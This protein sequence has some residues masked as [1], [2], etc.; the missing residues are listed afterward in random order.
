MGFRSFDGGRSMVAGSRTATKAGDV[1]RTAVVWAAGVFSWTLAMLVLAG[2]GGVDDG[3]RDVAVVSGTDPAQRA[4][5]AGGRDPAQRADSAGG[6]DPAQRAD[7][8][9]G[10]DPA[11]R[12]DSAGGR[13][14]AQHADSASPGA[15]SVQGSESGASDG[16]A[17]VGVG[18]APPPAGGAAAPS[19]H[20]RMGE[21][22]SAG[23]RAAVEVPASGPQG[24][25]LGPVTE[26]I[27]I[28]D[29]AE[30]GFGL[31][32]ALQKDVPVEEVERAGP[33]GAAAAG[34]GAGVPPALGRLYIWQ[35]G[36][37]THSAR[38]VLDR[39]VLDDGTV[40]PRDSV[41]DGSG[42]DGAG[43]D[44]AGGARPVFLSESGEQM[45]LPGGVILVLDPEWDADAVAGFLSRNG[46][47]PDRVSEL[48]YLPN[49]FVVATEP[50]FASLDLANALAGQA[51]VEIASPN[52]SREYTAQ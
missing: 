27:E 34:V 13:D 37:R 28:L 52:W 2:C 19:E 23:P 31:A 49:G 5:S 42:A 30:L 22:L 35:D 18:P 41:A 16:L 21:D 47:E 29:P 15:E 38:L 10:R 45:T 50:G 33:D 12:A 7:S 44:G 14:P 26:A 24:S 9:G 43:G 32:T 8:A 51:G 3:I 25:V 17:P 48:S 20:V 6:R 40:V 36:D 1:N 46:I 39:V 4:D 11:Q